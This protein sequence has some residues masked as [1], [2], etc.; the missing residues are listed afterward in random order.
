MRLFVLLFLFAACILSN[1]LNA[2][3]KAVFKREGNN[4]QIIYQ[5]QTI[6]SLTLEGDQQLYYCNEQSQLINN[7]LV[8]LFVITGHSSGALKI[9][10]VING[11]K[12]SISCESEPAKN[13][14]AIVRH[15]SGASKSLLNN[16]VYERKEDWLLSFDQNNSRAQINPVVLEDKISYEIQAQ[17]NEVVIRFRPLYYQQHRGLAYFKPKEYQVYKKPVVGW[18]SWFAYYDQIT[19]ADIKKTAD[20]ISEKFKPFGLSYLQIDDG[21]QQSPI[22]SVDSWLTPNEKFPSGL[23]KL[24]SYISS[25]GLQPGIW[26]NVAFADSALVFNNKAL[27]VRDKN[28]NPAKGK[29]VSYMM[30]GSNDATIEKFITPV[31]QQLNTTGWQY[32]KLDALRHLKYEGYNSNSE[33]FDQKKVNRDSAF[34]S[35]VKAVRKQTGKDHF[36]L[37]CWGIRPELV[38]VIDGCRIGSDGY[39]YAGLA[40]FNSYNNIIWRNDPDHIVLSKKEAYRSCS[41]TSLTGSLFMITDQPET[42]LSSTLIEA[43]RR[44]MPVLY[45][46][47][48]QVYDVDPSRSNKIGLYAVEMSGSGER[49]F[50]AGTVTTTGLFSLEINKPFEN[51]LLLGRMDERDRMIS[52]KNLGLDMAKTYLCFEFWTKQLVGEINKQF[53]PGPIDTGYHC[54]VFCFREKKD[55]PQLL[56]TNRHISCGGVD[57]N[58][59]S[60]NKNILSGTSEV[61]GNDLYEI[62][63]YEP[64]NYSV[65]KVIASGVEIIGNKKNGSVRTVSFTASENAT[66]KWSISY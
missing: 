65:N 56:A 4:I 41:A 59:L 3:Q 7:C 51:W 37:G 18:C 22:G 36:L 16:A 25:K 15:V 35:L 43:A 63:I 2:Q 13:E 58:E 33:F 55:H 17:G 27:F 31:Y 66:I 19:E 8:Q 29:W 40:Q 48:G 21:Y 12:T 30:D 53:Y 47:P 49:A 62:Y 60:W 11:S 50:D 45:T 28:G 20:V 38:G 52:L 6:A 61:V 24:A 57:L 26:T 54:Q 34:R 1:E 46:Q 9:T 5:Q 32:F 39:S 44:T 42:Y 14:A 64:D 23:S 10:G